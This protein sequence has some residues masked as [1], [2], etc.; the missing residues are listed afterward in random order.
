MRGIII[1][2]L[3]HDIESQTEFLKAEFGHLDHPDTPIHIVMSERS[4][5]HESA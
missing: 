1:V 4:K 2:G 5:R 3:D